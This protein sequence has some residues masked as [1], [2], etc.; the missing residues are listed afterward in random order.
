MAQ[1]DRLTKLLLS[2]VHELTSADLQ[3]ESRLPRGWILADFTK[4]TLDLAQKRG[5]PKE[6]AAS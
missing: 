3:I 6:A 2:L 4:T 5:S 1:Q